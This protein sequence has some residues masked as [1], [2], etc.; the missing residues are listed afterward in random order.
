M[1]P[2]TAKEAMK[3]CPMQ[4]YHNALKEFQESFDYEVFDHPDKAYPAIHKLRAALIEEEWKELAK[5]KTRIDYLDALCDLLYVVVGSQVTYG[6]PPL[7]AWQRYPS[8]PTEIHQLCRTYLNNIHSLFPCAK[9]LKYEGDNLISAI[10]IN[11]LN[12]A[13]DFVGAFLAVHDNNMKKLWDTP[14][15]SEEYIVIPKRGKYL[16]RRRSDGKTLKPPGY[17]PPILEPYLTP[18]P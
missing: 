9:R 14:P 1:T 16:V 10:H 17:M 13:A 8:A 4:V 3:P 18:E 12:N 7:H 5:A 15:N 2:L 6:I 11:G